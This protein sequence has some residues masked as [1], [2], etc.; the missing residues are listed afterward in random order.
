MSTPDGLYPLPASYFPDFNKNFDDPKARGDF[1][2]QLQDNFD[3]LQ[4]QV[5]GSGSKRVTSGSSTLTI[6]N[7]SSVATTTFNHTLGVVPASVV[8]T[9]CTPLFGSYFG[10]GLTISNATATTF[11]VSGYNFGGYASGV[12]VNVYYVV[13]T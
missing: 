11:D 1:L 13:T 4:L 6:P 10:T 9:G 3:R 8:A 5:G 12:V 7:L 2:Q